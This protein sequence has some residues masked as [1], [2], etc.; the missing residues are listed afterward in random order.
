MFWPGT[1]SPVMRL[2][3]SECFRRLW[4]MLMRRTGGWW[5]A[6][7][8][9]GG[10][11]VRPAWKRFAIGF[12]AAVRNRQHARYLPAI[13][14]SS[15]PT[16]TELTKPWLGRARTSP[17]RTAGH[18]CDVNSSR[19]RRTTL[20]LAGK[21]SPWSGNST[22]WSAWRP[23]PRIGSPPKRLLCGLDCAMSAPV[24]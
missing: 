21:C 18:M 2:W 16:A 7:L 24:A 22:P 10:R 20:R 8:R 19:P 1:W 6:R 11:G 4:F 3:G 14:A 23:E 12:S 15:W 5:M 17:W 13:E 9:A